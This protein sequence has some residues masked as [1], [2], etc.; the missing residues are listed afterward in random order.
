MNNEVRLKDGE[1]VFS[2]GAFLRWDKKAKKFYVTS[3]NN[4]A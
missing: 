4:K 1:E 2:D 3:L